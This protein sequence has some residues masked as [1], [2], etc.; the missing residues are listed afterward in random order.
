MQECLRNIGIV[1]SVNGKTGDVILADGEVT[2]Q[3]VDD[4]DAQTLSKSKEYTD[5]AVSDIGDT[6]QTE[7][8]AKV[9]NEDYQEYLIGQS[10]IDNAQNISISNLESNKVDKTVYDAHLTAQKAID[11]A[12][13]AKIENRVTN[14]S[15][16]AYKTAQSS[17]DSN[18]DNR[19]SGNTANIAKKQDKLVSGT[20]IKTINGTSIL[21][22]GNIVTPDTKYKAG[23]GVQITADNTIN[24]TLD[25]ELF[26]V[27]TALPTK[28]I[29]K[30]KIYLV[31][32]STATEK[33][34]YIEYIYVNDK[35]EIVGQVQ[36]DVDLS[37]YY[38][39]EET[40]A[41]LKA[42]TDDLSQYK[43]DQASIDESQNASISDLSTSTEEL[44]TAVE[45][46]ETDV[47]NK[48]NTT[49]F[50]EY[51]TAQA[52]IDSKQTEDISNK[53]DIL[54][55]WFGTA[56]DYG[57]IAIKDNNTF[58][59]IKPD[60]YTLR[61]RAI[62]NGNVSFNNRIANIQYLEYSYNNT[63]W[64][65]ITEL[66]TNVPLSAGQTLYVRGDNP[67]GISTSSTEYLNIK[68][69]MKTIMSGNIQSLLFPTEKKNTDEITGSGYCFYK[70]FDQNTNIDIDDNFK[71]SAT[72]L[73][74]A[75]Y[76]YMFNNCTSLTK[77]PELNALNAVVT[78]YAS[79]F[80][81]CTSLV[82]AMDVL[83]AT[84]GGN[85]CY[86]TMFSGCVALEKAPIIM[87][88]SIRTGCFSL[89]FRN[90]Q[91][92]NYIKV[93]TT[94]WNES[95]TSNWVSGVSPTGTFVK[96]IGVVIPTGVNGIPEGWTV[97][98]E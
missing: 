90:C 41:K 66:N 13:D 39:K 76:Y 11:D 31:P 50:E 12:Q 28:D 97:V 4:A 19:I 27:V 40:D 82:K 63:D 77:T 72:T 78:C 73:K 14:A 20:N 61:F 51:K 44:S 60:T 83:P 48:V 67:N 34:I 89:M 81:G 32:S 38:K 9:D 68:C 80:Q 23:T 57:E 46:I 52:E 54:K 88:E 30:N 85:Y 55:T 69:T 86:N 74:S 2:K 18:Q 5:E 36:A 1:R 95:Y 65:E 17:I 6:L 71:M 21:G 3:Y 26:E 45:K 98:E 62:A 33:N 42:I 47:Q 87:L 94:S 43:Q 7:I 15:F 96:P 53:Q 75:C 10:A 92:I 70:L 64:V 8:D 93:V 22:S 56:N 24:V 16:E 35:W 59:F 29:K 49:D 37:D 91:K 25:T 79:M 58:Y 84:V